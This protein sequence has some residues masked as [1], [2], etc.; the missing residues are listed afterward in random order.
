MEKEE[1][2]DST[3]F[4]VVA[5]DLSRISRI[6]RGRRYRP[7]RTA[8]QCAKKARP[9]DGETVTIEI[10]EID[11][12]TPPAQDATSIAVTIDVAISGASI[13]SSKRLYGFFKRD[14]VQRIALYV[15]PFGGRG[16]SP[17]GS[18]RGGANPE[19][20]DIDT[21]AETSEFDPSGAENELLGLGLEEIAAEAVTRSIEKVC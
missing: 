20:E 11:T 16:F 12:D 19:E 17:L 2:D 7:V 3:G 21:D 18:I 5:P 1:S 4:T 14:P 15:C 10:T 13:S 8:S 6:I 9:F